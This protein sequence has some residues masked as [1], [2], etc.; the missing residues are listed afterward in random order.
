VIGGKLQAAWYGLMSSMPG[1]T[2]A[3]LLKQLA[4]PEIEG[5]AVK[6]DSPIQQPN[7]PK[8]IEGLTDL[9]R[10][11]TA[12]FKLVAKVSGTPEKKW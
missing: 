6:A 12:S 10:T 7:W 9:V 3:E 11:F 4:A 5:D 2:T 1:A 8:Y